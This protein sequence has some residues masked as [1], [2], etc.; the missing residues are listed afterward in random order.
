VWLSVSAAIVV[1]L[2]AGGL[3]FVALVSL[4]I[5]SR[6]LGRTERE[7]DDAS[8]E[9]IRFQRFLDKTNKPLPETDEEVEKLLRDR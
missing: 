4:I 8:E 3:T 1:A 7:R 9:L 6:N 2:V 5:T